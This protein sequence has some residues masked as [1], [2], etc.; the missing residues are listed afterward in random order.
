MPVTLRYPA[1]R[2]EYHGILR[3]TPE[4]TAVTLRET[5]QIELYLPS[6]IAISDGVSYDNFDNGAMGEA[7]LQMSENVKNQGFLEGMKQS[8]ADGSMDTNATPLAAFGVQT[9]LSKFG[10]K[11]SGLGK[12]GTRTA[13]NPNTKALFKQVSLRQF[14]FT[15]KLIPASEEEA[16]TI[17]QIITAF[18][19]QMYPESIEILNQA[20]GY[21]FPGRYEIEAFYNGQEMKDYRIR[22]VPSY[23]T[24]VTTN[25]NPSAQSIMISKDGTPYFSEI[26]ITLAFIEGKT[27]DWKSVAEEEGGKY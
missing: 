27:L 11:A 24:N 19:T 26:D 16:R 12:Q 20:V 7:I 5:A 18:R 8:V 14:N 9:V 13:P 22:S 3:F 1:D 10:E 25:Y 2:Q 23:L 4:R 6:N 15:F 21:H 17:G